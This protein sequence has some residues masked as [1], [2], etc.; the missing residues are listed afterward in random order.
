MRDDK[1]IDE[2]LLLQI[3]LKNEN[4]R[5]TN[6]INTSRNS[7]GMADN[8]QPQVP[9][10]NSYTGPINVRRGVYSPVRVDVRGAK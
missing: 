3:G 8:V 4:Q 7:G 5:N 2:L 6:R 10:R 9:S 1:L